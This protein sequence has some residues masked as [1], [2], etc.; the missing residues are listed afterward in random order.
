MTKNI[1]TQDGKHYAEIIGGYGRRPQ[2]WQRLTREAK[3][4]WPDVQDGTVELSIITDSRRYKWHSIATFEV[5]T[6]TREGY[7]NLDLE[8]KIA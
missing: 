8:L 2:D 7:S 1:R 3:K 6:S 5:S 4:D